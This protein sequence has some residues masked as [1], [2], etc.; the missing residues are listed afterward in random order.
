MADGLK[1]YDTNGDGTVDVLDLVRIKKH[2]ANNTVEIKTAAADVNGD[3][4]I[5]SID[6]VSIRKRLLSA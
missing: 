1:L 2:L 4:V 3:D 5:D 6:F